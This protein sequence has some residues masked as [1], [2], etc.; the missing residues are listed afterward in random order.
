MVCVCGGGGRR[1]VWNGCLGG[2]VRGT[3]GRRVVVICINQ[4]GVCGEG[5]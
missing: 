4:A 2:A 5:S 1:V 3:R